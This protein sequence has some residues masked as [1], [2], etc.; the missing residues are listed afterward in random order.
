MRRMAALAAMIVALGLGGCDWLKGPAGPQGA[1][2]DKGEQGVAGPAGPPGAAGAAGVAG[3][4]GDRGEKGDKGERGDKGDKGD[5]GDPGQAARGIRV[6]AAGNCSAQATCR[7]KCEGNETIAAA[8]C[9]NHQPRQGQTAADPP[10]YLSKQEA[11]CPA[12]AADS[13]LALCISPN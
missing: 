4:K 9:N 1:K 12:P 13:M 7:V 3:A 5:K 8:V 2:G 6:P 10:K 11:E